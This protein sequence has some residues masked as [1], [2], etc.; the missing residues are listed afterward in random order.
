VFDLSTQIAWLFLLATPIACI[1]WTWTHE[2]LCREI[3]EF[4]VARCKSCRSLVQ[5]KFYFALT[6]EFC[7]SHYVT[8]GVLALTRF[9]FLVE[10]WRG[11]VI[12]LF[13]LVWIANIYMS[14]MALLRANL[15]LR[16]MEI[17]D[18]KAAAT[19]HQSHNDADD[20]QSVRTMKPDKVAKQ[21]TSRS[22]KRRAA[23]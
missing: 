15:K 12:A 13:S 6:C 3:Q 5:R 11:H 10:G 23:T 22:G 17:D 21:S 9:Q 19:R 20:G 2:E 18:R 1:S 7:F 14:L 4:L 8:I 16:R